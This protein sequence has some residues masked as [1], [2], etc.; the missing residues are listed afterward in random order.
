VSH[1]K[2][3][4]W[5]RGETRRTNATIDRMSRRRT[6]PDQEVF[7]VRSPEICGP[8]LVKRLVA[9]G[10][11]YRCQHC[12]IS[13][14]R[15]QPLVL[16]LDHINGVNDDNRLENLRLL[17]PNCHALTDTYCNRRRDHQAR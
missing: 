16:H 12:G 5:A 9:L 4:A 17:C 6:R 3:K 13:E 11:A 1:L 14:W 15:G 7:V 8:R 2:G 10:W